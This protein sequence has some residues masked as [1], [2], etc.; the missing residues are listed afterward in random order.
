MPVTPTAPSS[1]GGG[2]GGWQSMPMG[3]A[4]TAMLNAVGPARNGGTMPKGSFPTGGFMI[5]P[6]ARDLMP[7]GFT[8]GQGQAVFKGNLSGFKMPSKK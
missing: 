6:G 5:G 7:G 3:S 2:G 8:P 1:G 4:L